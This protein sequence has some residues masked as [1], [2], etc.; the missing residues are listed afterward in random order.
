MNLAAVSVLAGLLITA[1]AAAAAAAQTPATSGMKETHKMMSDADKSA[2][3]KCK[4]MPHEAMAKDA[5]CARIAKD[6]PHAGK[7]TKDLKPAPE[8]K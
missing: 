5:T 8:Q 4:A 2:W 6:Y 7:A 1:P 3:A